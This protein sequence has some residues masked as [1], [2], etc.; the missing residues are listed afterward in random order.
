[1]RYQPCKFFSDSGCYEPTYIEPH[2]ACI[3]SDR[4]D[5]YKVEEPQS[6]DKGRIDQIGANGNDGEHYLVEKVCRI[7]AGDNASQPLGGYSK[8]KERWTIHIKQAIEIIEEV[9]KDG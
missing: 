7:I 1:M 6:K 5:R 9:Q 3:G 8:G 2:H 4:C